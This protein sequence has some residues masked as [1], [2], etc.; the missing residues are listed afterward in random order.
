MNGKTQVFLP[1]VDE[2]VIIVFSH[3]LQHFYQEGIGLRQICD[4]CRLLW[5]YQDKIDRS[6]LK[7]RLKKMGCMSEWSAFAAL[8]VEYLGM[9][10]K[11][12]PFYYSDEKWK[13]KAN[14]I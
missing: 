12:M 2:D 9:S 5:T 13:K 4:W 6:L 1:Y 11:A 3:I 10:V 14:K 8:A 7:N